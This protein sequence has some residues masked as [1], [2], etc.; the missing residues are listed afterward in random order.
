MLLFSL[1]RQVK[2]QH[3]VVYQP[4]ISVFFFTLVDQQLALLVGCHADILVVGLSQLLHL[5]HF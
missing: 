5:L 3:L 2:C 4:G 1:L